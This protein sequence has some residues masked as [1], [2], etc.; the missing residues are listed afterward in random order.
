MLKAAIVGGYWP[1]T[2]ETLLLIELATARSALPSPLKSPTATETGPSPTANRGPGAGVKP[3]VPSPRR[4]ET[5]L[6]AKF[7]TARSALPS[8]LKSPTATEDGLFRTKN[9][10]PVADVKRPGGTEARKDPFGCRQAWFPLKKAI[11]PRQ[12]SR[13]TGV[14]PGRQDPGEDPQFSTERRSADP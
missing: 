9:G 5:S 8:R 12:A 4:T 3:P 11:R 6:L 14:C 7:A 13:M 1:R 10:E 2:M